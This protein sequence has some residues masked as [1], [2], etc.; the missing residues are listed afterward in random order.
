MSCS[1]PCCSLFNNAAVIL[2]A[3]V[4]GTLPRS[5]NDGLA[6]IVSGLWSSPGFP[7]WH[8]WNDERGRL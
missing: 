6:G 5:M 8:G 7:Y 4:L 2:S 1:A 3:G